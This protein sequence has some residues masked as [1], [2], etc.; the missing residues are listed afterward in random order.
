[1]YHDIEVKRRTT[2]VIRKVTGIAACGFLYMVFVL[3]SGWALPCPFYIVTGFRCP[4][5]GITRMFL[6]LVKLDW[7]AAFGCNQFLF[8]LLVPG[9][10][11]GVYS[12]VRYIRFGSVRTSQFE[13]VLLW[14]V[15]VAA[16][17]FGILRNIF[18]F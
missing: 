6:H 11:Y 18:L 15:L 5:C 4:G 12:T 17:I 7:A 10:L 8:V 1:M 9:L 13:N 3:V 16:I 2:Y 14:A